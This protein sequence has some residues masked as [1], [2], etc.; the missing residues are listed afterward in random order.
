MTEQE[1]FAAL[2]A[3]HRTVDEELIEL[4]TS[5]IG[6]EF[7]GECHLTEDEARQIATRIEQ[8]RKALEPFAQIAD[9]IAAV[10]AQCGDLPSPDHMLRLVPMRHLRAA[11]AALI[12]SGER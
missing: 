3:G 12:Q 8:L 4:L 7:D 9:D 5:R 11:R 1:A 10:E 6:Q 2:E